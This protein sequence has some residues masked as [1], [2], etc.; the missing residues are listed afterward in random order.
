MAPISVGS[1]D[2]TDAYGRPEIEMMKQSAGASLGQDQLLD[3]G[4]TSI[5]KA[6][7]PTNWYLLY[8]SGT[9]QIIQYIMYFLAPI[10]NLFF[11]QFLLLSVSE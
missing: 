6:R 5:K 8:L 10:L 1:S 2:Y 7:P 11:P 3:T 9:Y 4:Q